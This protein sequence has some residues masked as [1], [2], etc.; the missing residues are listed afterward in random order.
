MGLEQ[1]NDQR[2][3]T[4]TAR[5]LLA[6]LSYELCQ[7]PLDHFS[8]HLEQFK[9][10]ANGHNLTYLSHGTGR[11]VFELP[12][13]FIQ[14]ETYNPP[15][16]VKFP[17]AGD[18]AKNGRLQN[19]NEINLHTNSPDDIQELL[20]PILEYNQDAYWVVFPKADPVPDGD[21]Q[22][23]LFAQQARRLGIPQLDT[24]LSNIGIWDNDYYFTDYGHLTDNGTK[25]IW[26]N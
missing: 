10:R 11:I 7:P 1:P 22:A 23:Q 16:I 6:D 4:D 5:T 17:F 2:V 14:A 20:L 3:I 24:N 13:E 15:Y 18:D 9:T 25:T 19:Q 12:C 26:D 21:M 8:N